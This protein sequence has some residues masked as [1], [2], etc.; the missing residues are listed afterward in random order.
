[1]A[2]GGVELVVR[3]AEGG[4]KVWGMASALP[5]LS[6]VIPTLNEE[7]DLPATLSRARSACRDPR[8]T[9]IVADCGSRD[10]TVELARAGGAEVVCGGWSR[11]SAMNLGARAARGEY[12]LFLHADT[13]PPAGFDVRVCEALSKGGARGA[14]G[15][16]VGGAFDFEFSSHPLSRGIP[17]QMLKIVRITN[18][19]RFRWSGNFYGDQ[20]IFVSARVFQE[21]GGFPEVELMEDLEFSRK[22]RRAGRTV[23]LSPPMRTSPRRFLIRG[24]L[25]QYFADLS[26]LGREAMGLRSDGA[27]RVYNRLNLSGHDAEDESAGAGARGERGETMKRVGVSEGRQLSRGAGVEAEGGGLLSSSVTGR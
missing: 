19:I 18:R 26:L 10:R 9:F 20:G 6:V 15:G 21:V 11:A 17:R 3:G 2:A 25:R 12:L 23:I 4:G 27:Y 7:T 5:G 8:T 16:P 14:A 13:K 24:V 1:M 22:L